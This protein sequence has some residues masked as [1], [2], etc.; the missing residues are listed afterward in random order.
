MRSALK[1]PTMCAHA[2]LSVYP[3]VICEQPTFRL[4]GNRRKQIGILYSADFVNTS[5]VT[6]MPRTKTSKTELQR[7][8]I[9]T[10]KEV[11]DRLKRGH[12]AIKFSII[13]L[14]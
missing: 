14:T 3:R 9:F 1:I 13:F 6:I 5:R 12:G 7:N 8:Y 4:L 2:A 11:Y 10:K